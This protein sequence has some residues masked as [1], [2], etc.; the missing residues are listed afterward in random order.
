MAK[1][2]ATRTKFQIAKTYGPSVTMSAIT[3]A[4]EAVATLASGHGVQVGDYLEITSGWGN[5]NN[6]VVRVGAVS[7][8]AVTLEKFNSTSSSKFPAGAGIGSVRRITG[9]DQLSQVKDVS[10]AGGEQQWTDGTSLD[11]DVEIKMP[12]IKSGR[13]MTFEIFDDPNLPWYATVEAASDAT[14]NTGLLIIPPNN[15]KIVANALWSLLKEPNIRKNEVL[16]T[17]VSLAFAAESMRYA[18]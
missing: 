12:T 5:L 17:T 9:W 14:V 10:T 3:N 6:R 16:T 2:L 18:A 13:T 7:G 8:D 4:A 1:T 11:D 15:S